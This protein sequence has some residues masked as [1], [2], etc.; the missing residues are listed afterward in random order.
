MK[1]KTNKDQQEN[2]LERKPKRHEAI[3]WAKD[4]K[5]IVHWIS[6]IPAFSTG[7]HR[8]FFTSQRLRTFT[9]TKW[10]VL[11]GQSWMVRKTSSPLAKKWRSSSERKPIHCTKD[12]QN[13]FRY[14]TVI[15]LLPGIRNMCA[16]IKLNTFVGTLE[17]LWGLY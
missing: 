7:W 13:S 16:C 6:K 3:A 14:L 4:E 11:S 1:K 10:E 12:W 9:L 8:N 15:I 17:L 2:Y 5:G